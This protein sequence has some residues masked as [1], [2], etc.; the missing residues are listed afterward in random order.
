MELKENETHFPFLIRIL[1]AGALTVLASLLFYQ[2]ILSTYPVQTRNIAM[3]DATAYIVLFLTLF[4]LCLSLIGATRYLIRISL[5]NGTT[6]FSLT[7]V[8]LSLALNDR[9]SF[10]AFVLASFLYGLF[11]SIISSFLVYQPQGGFSK[12][13]GVSIP[14]ILPVICCGPLGQMPQFI[15]YLTQQFAILIVPTNLILLL[16]FSWLV[17][18]NVAIAVYSFKNRSSSLRNHWFGGF[19]AIVG[20]F[21]ACPTCAGFFFLTTLGLAG[22][23]TFALT[24]SSLQ[25]VFIGVGLPMLLLTPLITARKM[26]K[27]WDASCRFLGYKE[28][29]HR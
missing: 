24:L 22:A 18:L 28:T 5:K 29:S 14:S 15:V 10:R 19:G 23:V 2:S 4:G 26:P 3:L 21:T 8:I 16:T 1:L 27:D 7:I 13:D 25:I 20:I 6:K 12:P 17:G 11:F 9:R